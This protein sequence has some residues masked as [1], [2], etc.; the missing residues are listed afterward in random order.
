MNWA[1]WGLSV[2][3]GL[4]AHVLR[5]TLKGRLDSIVDNSWQSEGSCLFVSLGTSYLLLFTFL[6]VILLS[7]CWWNSFMNF[8]WQNNDVISVLVGNPKAEM[9]SIQWHL[10]HL[11]VSAHPVWWS[12]DQSDHVSGPRAPPV[13]V[14]TSKDPFR[15]EEVVLLLHHHRFIFHIISSQF[16]HT[17]RETQQFQ[18]ETSV[19]LIHLLNVNTRSS[20][21][22]FLIIIS[23]MYYCTISQIFQRLTI[24]GLYGTGSIRKSVYNITSDSFNVIWISQ[25]QS[26]PPLFNPSLYLLGFPLQSWWRWE[27]NNWHVI[28]SR[29][30]IQSS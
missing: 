14:E 23:D 9:I 7:H 30:Q 25:P 28:S 17:K 19:L 18:Q 27:M 2:L 12:V 11:S 26:E 6:H 5:W 24:F 20:S 13:P 29:H 10:K 1:S 21:L 16:I 15:C 3:D 8:S 22:I 4:G